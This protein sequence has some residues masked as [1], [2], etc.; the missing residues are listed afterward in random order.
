MVDYRQLRC[1]PFR[2]LVIRKK[3]KTKKK[4]EVFAVFFLIYMLNWDIVQIIFKISFKPLRH[5]L[6][7]QFRH[8]LYNPRQVS[9][10]SF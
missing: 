10:S 5:Q 6:E 4:P 8:L 2:L 1:P 3:K 9:F 7:F